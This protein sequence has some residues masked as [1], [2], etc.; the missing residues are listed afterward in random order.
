LASIRSSFGLQRAAAV[1]I[2][3]V[4]DRI[5][6][7]RLA[8]EQGAV[9]AIADRITDKPRRKKTFLLTYDEDGEP[10][11]EEVTDQPEPADGNL[12]E[13][14]PIDEEPAKVPEATSGNFN[15][16]FGSIEGA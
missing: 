3:A 10:V 8:V 16:V 12:V 1:A 15:D 6:G 7:E 14:P 11:I 13:A 2:F 5:A 9:V 4:A